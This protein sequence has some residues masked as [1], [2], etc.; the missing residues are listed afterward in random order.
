MRNPLPP[1]PGEVAALKER[2]RHEHDGHQK[3]RPRMRYLLAS[4]QA[5]T[6]QRPRQVIGKTGASPWPHATCLAIL[7]KTAQA[8]EPSPRCGGHRPEPAALVGS[9][10]E[11]QAPGGGRDFR[12][13]GDAQTLGGGCV[14]CRGLALCLRQSDVAP[15]PINRSRP[16]TGGDAD[17]RSRGL[18]A[19]ERCARPLTLT[20]EGNM[21]RPAGCAHSQLATKCPDHFPGEG[22]VDLTGLLV[23]PRDD[24]TVPDPARKHGGFN[25]GMR[26]SYAATCSRF[27]CDRDR[28]GLR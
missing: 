13:S 20:L 17:V 28:Q 10:H 12:L 21:P 5:H 15:A 7:E 1:I 27:V 24:A 23:P 4:G 25:R 9:S 2:L 22:S 11:G 19:Q 14:M 16:T 8:V 3:P 6:R 18:G 26:L